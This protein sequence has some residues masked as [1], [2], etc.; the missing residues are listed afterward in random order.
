ML[1]LLFILLLQLHRS[2]SWVLGEPGSRQ[3]FHP[4]SGVRRLLAVLVLGPRGPLS[5]VFTTTLH[6][7]K[8]PPQNAQVGLL[9]LT[10]GVEAHERMLQLLTLLRLHVHAG[11]RSAIWSPG[12][13]SFCIIVTPGCHKH[14]LP[15]SLPR[16]RL[17]CVWFSPGRKH[18]GQLAAAPAPPSPLLGRIKNSV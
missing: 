6:D 5:S 7:T 17:R 18:V 10:N 12:L 2:P 15:P 16:L 4:S 3:R 9:T 14:T 8:R 1:S 11:S 13:Q